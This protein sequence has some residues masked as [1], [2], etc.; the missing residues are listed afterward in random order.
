[1]SKPRRISS[2]QTI[3]PSYRPSAA[4][5]REDLRVRATPE[6]VR[7]AL[8]RPVRIKTDQSASFRRFRNI[9]PQ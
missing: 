4:E 2:L 6:Q 9:I 7:A 3:G 5:L 1:M 8:M